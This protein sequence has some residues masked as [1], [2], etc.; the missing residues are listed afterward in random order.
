[1]P[2]IRYATATTTLGAV[3]VAAS[4]KGLCAI[5]LGD[6][7]AALI[8]RLRKR[9]PGADVVP[10]AASFQDQVDAVVACVEDPR[11]GLALP[12]DIQ[13]TDFQ[14]SVW[15]AMRAVPAGSTISYAELAARSGRPQATRAVAQACGANQFAVVIPCHRVIRSDG[16]LGGYG[17]GVERKRALLEREA[18]GATD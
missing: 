8:D 5:T 13:G 10:A 11:R 4:E 6:D 16:T 15:E 7:G 12:L 17:G 1:M 9:F 2:T 14:Q 18:R 3:L